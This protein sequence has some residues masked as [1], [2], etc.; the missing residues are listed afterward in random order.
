MKKWTTEREKGASEGVE[1]RSQRKRLR[2]AVRL[3]AWRAIMMKICKMRAAGLE[4][5]SRVMAAPVEPNEDQEAAATTTAFATG[6]S[7][8]V[9]L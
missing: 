5:R 9:R 6:N 2:R 7:I 1:R 8:K 4:L 3:N